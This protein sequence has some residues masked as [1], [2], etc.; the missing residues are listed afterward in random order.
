MK[1]FISNKIVAGAI[2]VLIPVLFGLEIFE[3][4]SSFFVG[5][6]YG[7]FAYAKMILFCIF[8]V[9][10]YSFLRKFKDN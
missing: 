4:Y 7:K 3:S 10:I 8:V 5:T 9:G 6:F 2:S 1:K